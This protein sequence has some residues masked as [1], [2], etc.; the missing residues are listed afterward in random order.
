[1]PVPLS[2]N[3]SVTRITRATPVSP[4]APQVIPAQV[5]AKLSSDVRARAI[6]LFAQLALNLVLARTRGDAVRAVRATRKEGGDARTS[7]SHH[8]QDPR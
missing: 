6:G 4:Y 2:A 3:T 8:C 1:M 5:W 7:L